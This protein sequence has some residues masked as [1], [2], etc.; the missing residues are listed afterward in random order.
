[1]RFFLLVTSA[2]FPDFC[3]RTRCSYDQLEAW[4]RA[5]SSALF[6]QTPCRSAFPASSP[7][8]APQPAPSTHSSLPLLRQEKGHST[9][10]QPLQHLLLFTFKCL[11]MGR[12]GRGSCTQQP[13]VQGPVGAAPWGSSSSSGTW[14]ARLTQPIQH[15]GG[16]EPSRLTHPAQHGGGRGT[17]A[18]H[19]PAAAPASRDSTN[20]PLSPQLDAL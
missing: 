20:P 8:R 5:D 6:S 14:Q 7:H 19:W 17:S 3:R 9:H 1:M 13:A 18:P 11:S 4:K 10:S 16:H 12:E 2:F 15:G